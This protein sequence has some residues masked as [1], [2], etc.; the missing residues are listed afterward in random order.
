MKLLSWNVRGLGGYEKR[1]DVRAL[2]R[3][4]QP[5]I[6]CLQETKLQMCDVNVCSSVWDRQSAEF[7]FRPS[8]G[9]SRGLLTV[10]DASEVEV[11]SSGYFDHVLSIHG[12]FISSDEEFHLFNVYAPCD[13]GARQMLWVALTTRLQALRGKKVCICGDFNAV[14]SREERRSATVY[15]GVSEYGPFN[16]FIEEK[17]L[18]DLP[19]YGRNFTWFKGDGRSMSRLDRF[20]V[21]EEWNLVW[22][23]CIHVAHLRG[24]SDHCPLILSVD[25]ENWGPRPSRFLKCWSNTPG[26]KQFVTDKWKALQVEGW[27]GY[28]LKEKFKLIKLA[29]KEWH[30][31]HSHNVAVKIDSL[32]VRLAELD[33]KGKVEELSDA[34]CVELH[35]VS[36]NIHSLSRLHNSI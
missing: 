26:Y 17:G 35:G 25:E 4:K 12:R 7:S 28:V 18:L 22:P 23:N 16:Q 15:G 1:K 29:L 34:E 36:E 6:L 30:I 24:L 3:D 11:W 14:R 21:S 32:K 2:V 31:S 8:Q 33:G 20:L 5:L 19:L 9:A 27:G 10:W 13:G